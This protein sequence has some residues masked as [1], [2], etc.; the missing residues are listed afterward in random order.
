MIPGG[1]RGGN[2]DFKKSVTDYVSG[3]HLKGVPHFRQYWVHV[4]R[5]Y[6]FH[7]ILQN[8][9]CLGI[10]LK[11]L[12]FCSGPIFAGLFFNR[13]VWFQGEGLDFLVLRVTN[14]VVVEVADIYIEETFSIIDI[15]SATESG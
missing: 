8:P 6:F 7:A 13:V 4:V 12:Q 10:I 5:Y 14:V 11:M 3:G 15:V 1:L 9:V 2:F